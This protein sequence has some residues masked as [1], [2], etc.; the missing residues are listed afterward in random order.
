[1]IETAEKDAYSQ[2]EILANANTLEELRKL[3]QQLIR[4]NLELKRQLAELN[5]KLDLILQRLDYQPEPE[6]VDIP[7]TST[8]RNLQEGRRLILRNIFFDYNQA[9]LRSRSKHELN[10]LYDFMK[11]NPNIRIQ[12]SGHTDSRGNDEY[13]LRLSQD[14]AQAVVN[15]LVRN[16]IPA[17]RLSAV[18][19]GE[20][21]PI[22]RNENSDLTDTPV[23]RQLRIQSLEILFLQRLFF[24]WD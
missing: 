11:S 18:G 1:M 21:R 16:G 7:A 4:D 17:N 15:Y 24:H 20:T 9:T 13:N 19:Y 22:A 14:R 10:K 8:M 23:G 3:N 12:V 5:T 2:E 6:K